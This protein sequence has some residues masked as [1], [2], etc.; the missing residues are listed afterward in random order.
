MT[1]SKKLP[2]APLLLS[3]PVPSPIAPSLRIGVVV[4]HVALIGIAQRGRLVVHWVVPVQAM[5][6]QCSEVR[7]A[8]GE[9]GAA[10]GAGTVAFG[11]EAAHWVR[12]NKRGATNKN[13]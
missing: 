9:D 13:V 5:P 7:A 12:N 2:W 10:P 11:D 6:P 8:F 3:P 1:P 4:R